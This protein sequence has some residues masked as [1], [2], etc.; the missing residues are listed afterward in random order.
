[1]QLF[2][3]DCMSF[4]M[5]FLQLRKVHITN[6]SFTLTHA[7]NHTVEERGRGEKEYVPSGRHRLTEVRGL[8]CF[9]ERSGAGGKGG[10]WIELHFPPLAT[11]KTCLCL[12]YLLTMQHLVKQLFLL[13]AIAGM[14]KGGPHAVMQYVN[15]GTVCMRH[16]KWL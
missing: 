15:S 12:R 7:G 16:S 8:G 10:E 1:M 9:R 14:K 13:T 4:C 5:S 3:V 6:L 11:F 2:L